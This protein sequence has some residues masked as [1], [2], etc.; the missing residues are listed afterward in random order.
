M[1]SYEFKSVWSIDA[2]IDI[3]W[4]VIAECRNW[5]QWWPYLENVDV[6]DPGGGD[7]IGLTCRFVWRGVLPYSIDIVVKVT[8]V[9]KPFLIEGETSGDLEGTGRWIFICENKDSTKVEYVLDV[10]TTKPWM[11]ILA[12]ALSWFFKWNHIRVMAAGRDGLIHYLRFAGNGQTER[13]VE[14]H[15]PGPSRISP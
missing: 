8:R 9:Y 1:N 11:N 14:N 10:K 7:G 5:T 12:P 15:L 2:P 6:L 3:V 13:S 4:D